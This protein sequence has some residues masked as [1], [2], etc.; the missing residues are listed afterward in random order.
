MHSG[1]S[2]RSRTSCK[3]AS[4]TTSI[5][6]YVRIFSYS[7]GSSSSNGFS[8]QDETRAGSI[9]SRRRE[10]RGRDEGRLVDQTRPFGGLDSL[11]DPTRL[12]CE[13]VG[14]FGPTRPFGE[15]D[16]VFGPTRPFGELDD[17]CFAVRYLE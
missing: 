13:L 1:C 10:L 2:A 3:S 11:L 7:G 6:K 4:E 14:A 5:P 16:G 17:G 15:L 9:Q 8:D 12:F